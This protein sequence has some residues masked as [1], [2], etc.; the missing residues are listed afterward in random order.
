MDT[1]FD[2]YANRFLSALT[3]AFEDALPGAEVDLEGGVLTVELEDGGTY[4]INKHAPTRQIWVSSPA[5]GATHFAR[6][7]S[8]DRWIDTRGGRDLARMLRD[9]IRAATGADLALG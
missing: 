7:Q 8:S 3:T 1:A 2:S 9:E 6:D 4:V 5:S